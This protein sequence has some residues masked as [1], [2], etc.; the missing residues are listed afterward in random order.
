VRSGASQPP[1]PGYAE[2]VAEYFRRLA[3]HK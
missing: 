1:P 3:N 2:A